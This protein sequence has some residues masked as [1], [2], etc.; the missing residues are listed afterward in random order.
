M[1]AKTLHLRNGSDVQ[2]SVMIAAELREF[3]ITYKG[4]RIRA[5]FA[6]MSEPKGLPKRHI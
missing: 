1:K 6:K 5:V 2:D 4:V 3:T